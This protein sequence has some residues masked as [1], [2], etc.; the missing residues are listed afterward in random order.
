[1][2]LGGKCIAMNAHIRKEEGSKI[3]ILSLHPK[4]LE[5]EVQIKSKVSRKK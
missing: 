3:T 1:M 2:V 4:T 5:K